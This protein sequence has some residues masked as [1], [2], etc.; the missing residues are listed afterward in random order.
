[1]A[2][3]NMFLMEWLMESILTL[4]TFKRNR[5]ESE[6]LTEKEGLVMVEGDSALD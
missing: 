2:T 6:P 4:L 3:M 5:N 1:M